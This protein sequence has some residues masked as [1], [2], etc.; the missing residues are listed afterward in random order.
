MVASVA[1]FAPRRR[2]L[3]FLLFGVISVVVSVIALQPAR[4]ISDRESVRDL[5][6]MAGARGN[7]GTPVFY[8][9]C[10]DRT[11]E[12]YAGG[13]LAYQPNGEP[14]RFDGAQELPPAIRA[15]GHVALVLV[16]TRW[17]KQLTDYS[18]VETEKVGSN[19][20]VTLFVV[21]PR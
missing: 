10:D 20:W 13:R 2:V 11:A 17:E 4:A 12:F 6:R 14:I 16:E 15:K 19:G 7:G 8:F 9:L 18:G 21:R 5:M 1:L 3:N